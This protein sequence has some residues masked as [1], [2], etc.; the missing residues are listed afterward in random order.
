MRELSM[1]ILDLAQNSVAADATR[2]EIEVS[3]DTRLDTLRIS[4][5]DNGRG[6]SPAFVASVRDPFTT[7][8]TTRRVGMGIPMFAQAARAC[9]GGVT[10]ESIA[11]NGTTVTAT[12]GLSH[13]DRA[14]LGDM[15][16]TLVALVAAN[17]ET[18]I[19]YVQKTNGAEFV[20]D[21]DEIKA[22][23]DGVPINEGPVLKWIGDYVRDQMSRSII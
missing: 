4:I 13:I 6:M 14:P 8:R 16:G 10:V 3:A 7:T 20:L 11:G 21:T 22:W 2:I 9:G 17:P 5:R 1:H 15:A 12:F 18:S 19:R 23:L